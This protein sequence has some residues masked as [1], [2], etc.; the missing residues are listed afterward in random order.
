MNGSKFFRKIYK[1]VL[2]EALDSSEV[3]PRQ[4]KFVINQDYFISKGESS[5]K[6]KGLPFVIPKKAKKKNDPNS[7]SNKKK[8]QAK[9]EDDDDV[10]E[11]KPIG[12]RLLSKIFNTAQITTNIRS[13]LANFRT[14]MQ[15]EDELVYSQFPTNFRGEL[16]GLDLFKTLDPLIQE[17]KR[18]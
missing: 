8:N 2:K 11:S 3:S 4:D 18:A 17:E 16:Q 14:K 1:K 9:Y 5:E 12:S 7:N 13:F 15:T 6:A 10:L